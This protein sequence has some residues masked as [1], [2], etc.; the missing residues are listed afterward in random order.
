MHVSIHSM[1]ICAVPHAHPQPPPH[2]RCG[3]WRVRRAA[4]LQLE[5]LAST[6]ASPSLGSTLLKVALLLCSDPVDAVRKAAAQGLGA[7]LRVWGS[8]SS[9]GPAEGARCGGGGGASISIGAL[10]GAAQGSGGGFGG[11]GGSGGGG[12]AGAAGQE[13]CPELAQQVAKA[14]QDMVLQGT[15]LDP[16]SCTG[17]GTAQEAAAGGVP[18]G[19]PLPLCRAQNL[20]IFAEACTSFCGLAAPQTGFTAINT[21]EAMTPR[22]GGLDGAAAAAAAAA[23]EEL[24]MAAAGGEGAKGPALLAQLRAVLVA[25][26]RLDL[27]RAS[28]VAVQLTAWLASEALGAAAS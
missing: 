25:P 11:G 3:S 7:M 9:K 20:R 26:G 12:G 17:S 27:G 5:C 28:E 2:R 1:P 15:S 14:L 10:M 8:C 24:G 13:S 21:P 16:A 19:A 18:G 22:V 6:C 23:A 4:A